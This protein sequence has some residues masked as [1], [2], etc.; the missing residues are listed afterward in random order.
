[1]PQAGGTGMKKMVTGYQWQGRKKKRKQEFVVA[2]LI[3]VFTAILIF[4]AIQLSDYQAQ[5][6]EAKESDASLRAIKEN[7]GLPS[8][9]EAPGE[10]VSILPSAQSV[11]SESFLEENNAGAEDEAAIRAARFTALQER[12]PDIVGWLTM[13][14][15]DEAV[16][17]RDNVFYLDHDA[18]LKRNIN[19]ALFLDAIIRLPNHPKVI[20]IYG[21]NMHSGA[22]FGSLYKFEDE[23]YLQAHQLIRFES[24]A[25]RGEY[26]IFSAGTVSTD[27]G[28][29]NYLDIFALTSE[30][31]GERMNALQTIAAV[32]AVDCKV[33]VKGSD[34]ILLLITCVDH[35]VERRI[36]AAKKI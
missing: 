5:Q 23:K 2:A 8:F 30:E 10:N 31:E 35:D 9:T 14:G 11:S 12:N 20:I 24:A 17:Q 7:A 25:D 36:V 4:C 13:D 33:D 19:G 32:S 18:D 29:E 1:M 16:V 6:R 15:I 21:H 34:V 28:A 27:K 22:K 26:E 3:V